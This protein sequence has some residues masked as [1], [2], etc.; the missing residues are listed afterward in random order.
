MFLGSGFWILGSLVLVLGSW[1]WVLASMSWLSLGLGFG[2]WCSWI[3]VLGSWLLVLSYWFL[4]LGF[5]SCWFLLV[6]RL[7]LPLQIVVAIVVVVVVV[8]LGCAFFVRPSTR[9]CADK[10][11]ISIRGEEESSLSAREEEGAPLS[12]REKEVSFFLRKRRGRRTTPHPFNERE[13]RKGSWPSP[14]SS[15]AEGV[16]PPLT[17][18]MKESHY[19][20]PKRDQ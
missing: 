14:C 15:S 8:V 17:L 9:Q 1:F 18:S 7:E 13:H 11:P 3:L 2:V 5:G 19:S 20:F 6:V 16:A 10:E 4:V 12:T